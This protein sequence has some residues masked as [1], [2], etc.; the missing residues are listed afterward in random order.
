MWLIN[1]TFKSAVI[2]SH[3][4]LISGTLWSKVQR[5]AVKMLTA[6]SHVE[7]WSTN[8]LACTK[9]QIGKNVYQD[10]WTIDAGVPLETVQTRKNTS[11]YGYQQPQKDVSTTRQVLCPADKASCNQGLHY[12][13]KL[14]SVQE[15]WCSN[16]CAAEYSSLLGCYPL[17]LCQ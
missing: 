8:L 2:A 3:C 13:Y 12:L 14:N 10:T 9:Q 17:P 7:A 1:G 4:F 5:C 11:S 16:N 6:S 15:I